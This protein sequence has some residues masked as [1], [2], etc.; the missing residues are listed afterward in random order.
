MLNNFFWVYPGVISSPLCDYMVKSAPWRDKYAAELSKDNKN[1]FVDDEIRKT[2]VTF[3]SE[4]SPIG[5]MM[6]TYTHL[7]NKEAGWNFD[8][9]GF[10][11]IQVGK[12]EDNGHYDWHID[13]FVPDHNNKQRKLSA[14]AFLSDPDTY[15]GGVFEFKIALLPEKMPKGTIIVFP[16]VL[17]HRVTAVEDGVRYSAAC[18]AFGPAFR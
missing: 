18:W 7:A 6:Q 17:E 12:Y 9:D 11:K 2:E 13:S 5:C 14:I 3:T 15:E 16:S 8:I 10:E 1:L 4:Y